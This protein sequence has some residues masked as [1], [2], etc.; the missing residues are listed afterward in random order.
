VSHEPGRV[1]GKAGVCGKGCGKC[2]GSGVAVW[3]CVCNSGVVRE[4]VCGVC[5]CVC[6]AKCV[7]SVGVCG[8]QGWCGEVHV[9]VWVGVCVWWVCGRH[10]E[11]SEVWRV[12]LSRGNAKGKRQAKSPRSV[13]VQRRPLR[14]R[15]APVPPYSTGGKSLR[16]S[17][18][19]RV[20]REW[21]VVVEAA[22]RAQCGSRNSERLWRNKA[23][24]YG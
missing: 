8:G 4:G 18:E 12:R 5:V 2:G 15:P 23:R 16:G 7:C 6:V 3:W 10:A 21:S 13:R 19:E 17:T 14:Q 24:C 1:W 20:G 9:C 22:T 11:G